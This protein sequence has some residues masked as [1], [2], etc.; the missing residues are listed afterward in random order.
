MVDN[1]LPR[2]YLDI[3]LKM[4]SLNT[5]WKPTDV[6]PRNDGFLVSL[7]PLRMTNLF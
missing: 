1:D 7:G 4:R 5:F 2:K 3:F 6:K